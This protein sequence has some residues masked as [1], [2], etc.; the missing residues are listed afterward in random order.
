VVARFA[1]R[2]LGLPAGDLLPQLI[3]HLSLGTA[4]AAYERWLADEDAD[5]AAL[6][7]EAFRTWRLEPG[8]GA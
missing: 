1:A 8:F 7:V 2:R 3:G 5:L 6:L 4:V